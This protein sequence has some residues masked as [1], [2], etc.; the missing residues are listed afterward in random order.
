[1]ALERSSFCLC[2]T[3]RSSFWTFLYALQTLTHVQKSAHPERVC[4]NM[5]TPCYLLSASVVCMDH[6]ET[7]LARSETN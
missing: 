6:L 7:P 4:S 3:A 1:M 5:V 2:Y